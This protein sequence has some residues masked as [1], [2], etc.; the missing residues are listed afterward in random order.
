MPYT[1]DGKRDRKTRRNT[2]KGRRRRS[3]DL[4]CHMIRNDVELL[5]NDATDKKN[6]KIYLTPHLQISILTILQDCKYH[7][8][9]PNKI[10]KL[11]TR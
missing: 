1:R 3:A 10:T 11:I 6:K 7:L 9:D 5:I 4:W 8:V 2:Q